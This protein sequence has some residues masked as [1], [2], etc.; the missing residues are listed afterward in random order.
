M[1][2]G[3][4]ILFHLA[5]SI[6]ASLDESIHSKVRS[7]LE[8]FLPSTIL[9]QPQ[10]L[11]WIGASAACALL[12]TT[13]GGVS[14]AWMHH[15]FGI[16]SDAALSHIADDGHNSFLRMVVPPAGYADQ[17]I[18]IYPIGV[19]GVAQGLVR[20][21]ESAGF[22]V[23]GIQRENGLTSVAFPPNSLFWQSLVLIERPFF[24]TAQAPQPDIVVATPPL[25]RSYLPEFILT[26]LGLG[27]I[28]SLY[29]LNRDA[30]PPQSR[31]I[32]LIIATAASSFLSLKFGWP[33]ISFGVLFS[34]S[35]VN[36]S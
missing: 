3:Y 24:V 17:D 34:H 1:S 12:S 15:A 7:F 13:L 9:T 29:L 25:P 19:E 16:F 21:N 33:I 18:K 8:H 32:P 10:I 6:I 11:S 5:T 20:A 30:I 27:G 4:L 36:G 28:K 35:L 23:V 26:V 2:S 22:H 14:L 31:M